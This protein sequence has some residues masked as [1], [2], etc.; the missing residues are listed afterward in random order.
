[1]HA[2]QRLLRQ[3]GEDGA[4][5]GAAAR[6]GLRLRLR[7]RRLL[8]PLPLLRRRGGPRRSSARHR[9]TLCGGRRTYDASGT[10]RTCERAW[11]PVEVAAR[12]GTQRAR[13]TRPRTHAL[14]WKRRAASL[15]STPP[16]PAGRS[17]LRRRRRQP[18]HERRENREQEQHLVKALGA[19]LRARRTKSATPKAIFARK[20]RRLPFGSSALPL[21][22]RRASSPALPAE[23][24]AVKTP[25]VL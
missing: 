15:M 5:V 7:L 22:Q 20:C 9:H 3:L 21:C 12:A 24:R 16:P 18:V 13:R 25:T 8:R 1:M 19:E 2:A 17:G 14:L 23:A 4:H 6:C 10:S 11:R